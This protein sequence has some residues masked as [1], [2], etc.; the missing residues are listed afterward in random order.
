MRKSTQGNGPSTGY[1]ST[2][3]HATSEHQTWISSPPTRTI[4]YPI[5]LALSSTSRGHGCVNIEL[6]TGDSLRFPPNSIAPQSHKEDNTAESLSDAGGPMVVVQ[7]M[8]LSALP[9]GAGDAPPPSPLSGH[10]TPR[11]HL[12]PRPSKATSDRLATEQRRLLEL[13]LSREVTAML[14]ASRKDSTVCMYNST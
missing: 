1:C 6:A 10:A 14:L 3:L 13:G 7:A 9:L 5:F 4:K 8:V 12:S 11:T 2:R